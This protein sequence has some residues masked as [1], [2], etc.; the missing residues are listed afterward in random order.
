MENNKTLLITGGCG[1]IGSNLV[2]SCLQA[3][4][5]VIN[6]DNLTYAGNRSSLADLEED[7]NYTF[8]HGDICDVELV[9][10]I[11]EE[12]HPAAILHLAA[13][14]HVDRSIDSPEEFIQ[15]NIVGT[16]RLL[17]AALEYFG[18]LDGE[19]KEHFR[20]LHVSTDEVFGSIG[21]EGYFT[22]STLYDPRSSASSQRPWASTGWSSRSYPAWATWNSPSSPATT[23][24]V[25]TP[26]S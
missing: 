9:R 5:R 3:G 7:P 8:I 14:S 23:P 10:S 6:L 22:E 17:S 13:E 20:F 11:L 18:T 21:P 16:F 24:A 2:R 25:S 12:H 1:F 15:T 26:A 4:T 19:E